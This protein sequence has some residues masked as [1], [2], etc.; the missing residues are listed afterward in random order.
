MNWL[1]CCI[2]ET[3]SV[4]QTE[5]VKQCAFLTAM[6]VNWLCMYHVVDSPLDP[7]EHRENQI[8]NQAVGPFFPSMLMQF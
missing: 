7:S 8:T 4:N 1:A 6:P 3:S 5:G 2:Q